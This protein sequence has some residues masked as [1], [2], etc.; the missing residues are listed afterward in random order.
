MMWISKNKY[1]S[2]LNRLESAENRIQEIKEKKPEKPTISV[3]D[4]K[5]RYVSYDWMFQGYWE[6]YRQMPVEKDVKLILE[7]LKL[8]LTYTPKQ[9]SFGIEKIKPVRKK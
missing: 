2:I 5:G 7:H 6:H 4:E 9:E 1:Q 3:Y 8:N